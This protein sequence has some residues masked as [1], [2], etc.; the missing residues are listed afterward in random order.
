[1]RYAFGL[2]ED[3]PERGVL[4]IPVADPEGWRVEGRPDRPKSAV[5]VAVKAHRLYMES[6]VWPEW[7]S[8]FA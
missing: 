2:G 4:V 8:Y 7:A 5:A 1:V 6:G 3:D